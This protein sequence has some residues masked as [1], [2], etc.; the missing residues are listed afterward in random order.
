MAHRR[1]RDLPYTWRSQ[2]RRLFRGSCGLRERAAGAGGA[3]GTIATGTGD[4]QNHAPLPSPWSTGTGPLRCRDT[5]SKRCSSPLRSGADPVARPPC[6]ART[7]G[8]AAEVV[9]SIVPVSPAAEAVRARGGSWAISPARS[10]DVAL[11]QGRARAA[12]IIR[13]SS[14]AWMRGMR[15]VRSNGA[16][17]AVVR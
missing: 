14:P 4:V 6:G 7:Y 12:A 17:T 16:A 1:R 11:H 9:L 2:N 3:L 5:E 10:I 8:V 13:T 15:V